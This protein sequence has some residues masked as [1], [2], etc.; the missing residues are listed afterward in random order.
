MVVIISRHPTYHISWKTG[1]FF[2]TGKYSM[3]YLV[4]QACVTCYIPVV[5]RE[6]RG[7]LLPMKAN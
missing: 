7:H 5:L 4:F 6:K 3:I 1:Y 2:P